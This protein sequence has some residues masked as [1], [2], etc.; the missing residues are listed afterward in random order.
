MAI[1]PRVRSTSASP[2]GRFCTRIDE[3]FFADNASGTL[4]D[5]VIPRQFVE[6][7]QACRFLGEIVAHCQDYIATVAPSPRGPTTTHTHTN[8]HAHTTKTSAPPVPMIVEHTASEGEHAVDN[9]NNGNNNSNIGSNSSSVPLVGPVAP[10]AVAP[11]PQLIHEKFAVPIS[12]GFTSFYSHLI[13]EDG[14]PPLVWL[15]TEG[16][17]KEITDTVCLDS[18]LGLLIGGLFC[19]QRVSPPSIG[20]LLPIEN[21][22]PI[23]QLTLLDSFLPITTLHK[24]VKSLFYALSATIE[25]LHILNPRNERYLFGL[26]DLAFTVSQHA[27]AIKYYMWGAGVST[28]FFCTPHQEPPVGFKYVIPRLME[29]LRIAKAYMQSVAVSQLLK[30]ND[31]TKGILLLQNTAHTLDEAYF[32][33]IWEQPILEQLITLHARMKQERK[34]ALVV[35]LMNRGE[36]NQFNIAQFREPFVAHMKTNLLRALCR[37]FLFPHVLS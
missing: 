10:P 30:D 13:I 21:Y 6:I 36:M 35:E 12:A 8:T 14:P 31:N 15:H 2:L 7:A 32:E 37:E 33:Y 11:S 34:L 24:T 18:L 25:R 5:T 4:S 20:S 27:E 28:G 16:L 22:G 23:A 26:G 3:I 19:V 9:M 17:L 1:D 29:S